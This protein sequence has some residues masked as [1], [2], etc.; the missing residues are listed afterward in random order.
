M[1][2][3]I[4]RRICSDIFDPLRQGEARADESNLGLGLYI[5]DATAQGHRG[6]ISVSSTQEDGTTFTV[7][8]LRRA[9][10]DLA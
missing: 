1:N 10:A 3:F 5:A 7:A 4:T 8:L 9:T 6:K 2:L